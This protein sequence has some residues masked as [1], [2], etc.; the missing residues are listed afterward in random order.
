M[1]RLAALIVA[2]MASF[3]FAS[4]ASADNENVSLS[5]DVSPKAGS[6]FQA[7]PKAADLS[8]SARV[9]VPEGTP[10]VT[11]TKNIKVTFPRNMTMNPNNK[12]TPVCTDSM[13]SQATNLSSP[14]TVMSACGNSVVGTGRAVLYAA[15]QAGIVLDSPILVAFNA[16]VKNGKPQLKIWG[17]AFQT[18]YGILMNTELQKNGVMDI[19]VPPL[20]YDS[21]VKDFRLQFPGPPLDQTES[22]VK[23]QGKD[24]NYIRSTCPANGKLT[25]TA[26]FVLQWINLETGN[27]MGPAETK[28]PEPYTDDCTGLPGKA[29]LRVQKVNGPNAVKNGRKGTFRVVVRNNGTGVAK[30][31]LVNAAGA[32]KGRGKGGNIAPGAQKVVV[33]KTTVRGKKNRRVNVRFVAKSG[34]VKAAAAKK[35]RVK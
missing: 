11:P 4:S 35:V 20:S 7:L 2:L 27:P 15:R 26:E 5:V 10:L 8:V 6:F 22:G 32:G 28:I 19:A 25:S 33:V 23:T 12:V 34:N 29:K 13:L 3:A 17:Y 18:E 31:V 24:P 30:N 16:G 1:K 9:D 21:A 14:S